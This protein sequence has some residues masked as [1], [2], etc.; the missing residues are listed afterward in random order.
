MTDLLGLVKTTGAYKIV[1]GDKDNNRLSHAY[2]IVTPDGENL[3]EYLKIFAS[4]VLCDNAHPCGNCRACK[5]IKDNAHSDVIV[6]PKNG[7]SIKTEEVNELIGES[8]VKPIEGEKK[9]FILSQAQSMNAQAQNKLLKTLEEPPKNVHIFMGA[10]SEF[11]LLTTIKSRVKKLEIPPYS[12][13]ELFRALKGEYL[14]QEKLKSAI[15]CGDGTVG[16]AQINYADESLKSLTALCSEIITDMNSSSEVLKYSNKITASKCDFNKFLSVMELLLNDLLLYCEGKEERV[17]NKTTFETIKSA[18]NFRTG[19]VIYALERVNEA[20]K[21]KNFNA[22]PTML[23]EWL[24][25]QIL[26]GKYKWQK[27]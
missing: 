2:L 7:P 14:D 20:K 3:T 6:Y 25:F 11:P 21:R 26:E 17:K 1:K 16:M 13:S 8:F 19:S 9:I 24:L 22:N 12:E 5:L 15:S 23:T 18:K 27:L 4:V 10:T